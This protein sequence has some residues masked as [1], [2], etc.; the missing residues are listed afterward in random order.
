MNSVGAS[1]TV[2][3][4]VVDVEPSPLV[5]VNLAVNVPVLV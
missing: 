5:A 4:R 1:L 2:M 3:V